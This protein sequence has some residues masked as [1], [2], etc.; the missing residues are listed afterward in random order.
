MKKTSY[1]PYEEKNDIAQEPMITQR[2]RIRHHG[3][4]PTQ[5]YLLKVFAQDNS[6]ETAQDIQKI[7]FQYYQ[8]K[9]DEELNKAWDEGILDQKRLNELRHTYH[10]AG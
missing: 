6:E 7:V 9:M 3:L 2:H 5:Q 10:W 4:T 8:K 1:P